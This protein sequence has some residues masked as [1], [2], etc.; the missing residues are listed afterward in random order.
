MLHES[1]QGLCAVHHGFADYKGQELRKLLLAVYIAAQI[2]RQAFQVT[3]YGDL[4]NIRSTPIADESKALT[5]FPM[6]KE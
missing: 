5:S 4:L 3:S 2:T 1:S 6:Q